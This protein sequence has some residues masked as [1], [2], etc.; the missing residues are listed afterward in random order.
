MNVGLIDVVVVILGLIFGS[1]L[2]VCVYRI[3]LGRATGLDELEY[4]DD[5]SQ[6]EEA[7]TRDLNSDFFENRVTIMYPPRSFCPNCG[8]QLQWRYNIPVFGWILLR[9]RSACCQKPI[10]WRYPFIELLSAAA[11]W[12]AYALFDPVT[13]VAAYIFAATLIVISFIDIDYFIIPNVITYPGFVL[14]LLFGVEQHLYGL[15]QSP[16]FVSNFYDSVLGVVFGA[17]ILLLI[18]GFYTFV[19]KKQGLG[20]GDVKLLAVTGAFFGVSGAFYTIFVGSLVGSLLGIALVLIGKGKWSNYLPFGPYL[21][22]AN[23]L[24]LFMAPDFFALMANPEAFPIPGGL[25]G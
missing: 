11:A 8:T 24:Y 12:G 7:E 23:A 5:E 9:G 18:S 17:G 3:P 19:R 13:A 1:F 22:I 21:A 16:P 4:E 14:G 15:V 25:H 6:E 20:M 2:S 10:S